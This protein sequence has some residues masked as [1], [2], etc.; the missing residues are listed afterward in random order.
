VIGGLIFATVSTLF[1]VPVVF[2]IIHRRY[3]QKPTAEA[4]FG[5][6]HVPV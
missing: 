3:G 1:F 2:S 4:S 6:T 5:G